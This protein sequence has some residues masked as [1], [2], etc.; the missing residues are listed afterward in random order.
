MTYG[1]SLL[2]PCGS[3]AEQLSPG[4]EVHMRVGSRSSRGNSGG[5]GEESRLA[6]GTLEKK[7]E[8]RLRKRL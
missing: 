4:G 6:C 7:A 1:S 8:R 5:N 2:D 3:T